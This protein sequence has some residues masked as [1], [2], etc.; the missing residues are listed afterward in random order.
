MSRRRIVVAGL[1]D[2]GLLTAIRLARYNDVVGISVKP[3]LVSGQELG[4]RLSR[5]EKWAQNY[6]ISFDRFRALDRVRTAHAT[7]TGV[8]LSARTIFARH[9]DGSPLTEPYDTLIISTGVSNGFW[10]QPNL[11]SSTDV[12]SDL[13]EAHQ[14]LAS[15]GSVIVI[16]GGAAA[17]SSA[18]NVAMRWPG[19]T[20]D[21]YFPGER[22]LTHHAP[23]VWDRIRKRLN[24]LGV[25]LHPRHRALIPDGFACDRITDQPVAWCSGQ[26]P[27]S[28]DAVIWAIGR[29]R[30]NTDWLPPALLDER[31][32]VRVTPQLQVPDHPDVFAVG[33]V[34]ATDPLRTSARNRADRLVAHNVRAAASGRPLRSYRP[35]QH[36]WGSVLGVQPDGLEVFT[37]AGQAFRFPAWSIERVLQPWIVRR[38]I[39]H[40]IRTSQESPHRAETPNPPWKD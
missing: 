2:S 24:K 16:G 37:P 25:G 5:P 23:K 4:V 28:A 17:V 10:R 34:A 6:W 20:V 7:L 22:P 3:G 9:R 14:R 31:G 39:Y 19:L 32:F 8:N 29:V 35:P 13:Y 27:A 11:Q 36:R 1:G 21:L 18:A 15:A 30:P 33:D 38:G 40:G 12:A 26:P